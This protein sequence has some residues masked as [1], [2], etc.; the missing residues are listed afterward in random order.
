MAKPAAAR[1]NRESKAPRDAAQVS[2]Y[3]AEPRGPRGAVHG[4]GPEPRRTRRSATSG[5]TS[6]PTYVR[7]CDARAWTIYL[8]R[9]GKRW[10]VSYR[11]HSWR[12][13]GECRRWR[14]HENFARMARPLEETDPAHVLLLVLTFDQ[15]A[16]AA[17]LAMVGLGN[18]LR[19][20]SG[21]PAHVLDV[22]PRWYAFR[23][24]W[25]AWQSLRQAFHR[26]A[27]RRRVRRAR[28]VQTVEIHG[29]GWPHA[30]IVMEWP[31]LADELARTDAEHCCGRDR[32]GPERCELARD[33]EH[34]RCGPNAGCRCV[35][36]A[37]HSTAAACGHPGC[38]RDWLAGHAKGCGWGRVLT[39]ERA[40]DREQVAGY[41][42]KLAG[43]VE[44]GAGARRV[45]AGGKREGLEPA[46]GEVVKLSQAPV[47]AP[48]HFR[49]LRYSLRAP[50]AGV[51]AMLDP[52]HHDPELAGALINQPLELVERAIVADLDLVELH[53]AET[54]EVFRVSFVERARLLAQQRAPPVGW[55]DEALLPS[56]L[57]R[58]RLTALWTAWTAE[59]HPEL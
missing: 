32:I 13:A 31:W 42:V 56:R 2:S 48:P 34:H 46:I 25:R 14:A 51:T 12:H 18:V 52:P 27:A 53:S 38:V 36:G 45:P 7:A 37:T 49:R 40:R 5:E 33:D 50:R 8:T 39:V 23:T 1:T 28:W 6:R 21:L 10:A 43:E 35:C 4:T 26:E 58:E 44:L 57:E 24:M 3:V 29:T 17:G 16:F 59:H 20:L 9:G 30:N 55:L 41:I 19:H 54:G 15:R 11:C 47:N 22:E